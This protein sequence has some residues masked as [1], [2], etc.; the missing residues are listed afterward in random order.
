MAYTVT[1]RR[2]ATEA[3]RLR[4]LSPNQAAQAVIEVREGCPQWQVRA[5][6]RGGGR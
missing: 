4:G 6:W 5:D 2:S 3:R 1:V